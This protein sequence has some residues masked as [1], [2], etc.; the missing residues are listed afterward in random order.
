MGKSCWNK[1]LLP[2]RAVED[3][4][5]MLSERRRTMPQINNHVQYR[6]SHDTN[7][8]VLCERRDLKMQPPDRAT[9]RRICVVILHKVDHDS[10]LGKRASAVCLGKEPPFVGILG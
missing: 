4:T 8:L 5:L 7:K 2:I 9:L 6:A 10:G 1:E 3:Q